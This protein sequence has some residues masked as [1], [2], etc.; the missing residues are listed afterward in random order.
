[1]IGYGRA[2]LLD[3]SAWVKAIDRRLT[4]PPRNRFD[5]ALAAGELWTCPPTLLEMLYSAR[6]DGEFTAIS[7][8]LGAL[9]HTSLT[10]DAA[11]RA[12]AAQ[13][14]LAAAPGV[15]HRV[16]PM[17]LLIA[18]VAAGAELGVL[19]YDRDYDTIAEHTPLAFASVWVAPRGSID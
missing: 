1:L 12:L 8:E 17:D 10:A 15:S 13:A 5:A 4:G 3:N 19:H 9:L 6:D 16:K 11:A 2:L 18:A 14:Q 7:A